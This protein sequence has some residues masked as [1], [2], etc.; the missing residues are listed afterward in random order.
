MKLL[1]FLL[2]AGCAFGQSGTAAVKPCAPGEGH[3]CP[4]PA[5]KMPSCTY[6]G[7]EVSGDFRTNCVPKSTGQKPAKKVPCP[8][9][10]NGPCNW[11][12]AHGFVVT[13]KPITAEGTVPSCRGGVE[14]YRSDGIWI[15]D[16]R[17]PIDV[18]AIQETRTIKQEPCKPMEIMCGNTFIKR[19]W[20]CKDKT[21]ILEHD[22]QDPPKYY[23]RRVQP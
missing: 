18:P 11:E 2:L 9:F 7:V 23:C 21:R 15:C 14:A 5:R 8:P 6:S 16:P 17:G 20:T 1:L 3:P 10:G 19:E 22:E 13:D 12:A 4:V